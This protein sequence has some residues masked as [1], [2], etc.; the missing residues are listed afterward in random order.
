[1]TLPITGQ[2]KQQEWNIIL[3]VAKYNGFPLQIIRKLRNKILLKTQR[4][5]H[6]LTNTTKKGSLSH[7]TF[8]LNIR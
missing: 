5:S 6:S 3:T 8:H 2:A 4:K 1:M 7:I